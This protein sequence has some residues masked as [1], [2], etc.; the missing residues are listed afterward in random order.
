MFSLCIPTI[1]RFNFL[2][3]SIPRYLNNKL[4]GEIIICDENG[5]D[6]DSISKHFQNEKI[7]LY[8]NKE[9]LG[10]FLN[11]LKCCKLASLEWIAL[12]DSDNFADEKYFESAYNFIQSNNCNN[13]TI[14]SPSFAKPRFDYRN[15]IGMIYKK[16]NFRTNRQKEFELLG[17]N[18]RSEILMNTGNYILNR[19]LTDNLNIKDN[20]NI[21]K[22]SFACDVI[23]MNTMFFQQ[24]DAEL[25]VVKDME[26]DHVVHNGS[27]YINTHAQ[28]KHTITEVHNA[29]RNMI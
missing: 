3:D 28:T 14:L 23:L 27:I 16:N 22:Q 18:E 1:D 7:K 13:N 24:V 12:I 25:Y 6:Y 8:V 11:K 9:Q 29:Y 4:I 21:I 17:S 15:L 26:Y 2:K 5:N 10:P 19:H 20:M